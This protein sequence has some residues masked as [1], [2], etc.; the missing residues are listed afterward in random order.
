MILNTK[1]AWFNFSSSKCLKVSK[2]YTTAVYGEIKVLGFKKIS[3]CVT[4]LT[5]SLHFII[6]ASTKCYESLKVRIASVY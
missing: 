5:S 6:V 4:K 3:R 2:Y 1:Q